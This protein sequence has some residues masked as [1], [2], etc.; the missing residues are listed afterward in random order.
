MIT[1]C[2]IIFLN[3]FCERCHTDS[4]SLISKKLALFGACEFEDYEEYVPD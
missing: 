1:L 4:W 3:S 2:F